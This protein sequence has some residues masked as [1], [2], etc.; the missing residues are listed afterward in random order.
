MFGGTPQETRGIRETKKGEWY[1]YSLLH[2]DERL[3]GR[4]DAIENETIRFS[5]A[6]FWTSDD[7][8]SLNVIREGDIS[9]PLSQI[10]EFIPAK[11]A[12]VKDYC[13]LQNIYRQYV[14]KDVQIFCNGTNS[15]GHLVKVYNNMFVLNPYFGR[16]KIVT[17]SAPLILRVQPPYSITVLEEELEGLAKALE[18]KKE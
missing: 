11:E 18:Q 15:V 4:F 8:G 10:H 13:A 12:E 16:E 5:A 9:L 6:P 7:S 14:G 1:H 17:G 3:F 2:R